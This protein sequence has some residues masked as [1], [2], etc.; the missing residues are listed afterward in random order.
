ME[1]MNISYLSIMKF[2]DEEEKY[3][4][5]KMVR[6]GRAT[7]HTDNKKKLNKSPMPNSSELFESLEENSGHS[8]MRQCYQ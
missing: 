4:S 8:T 6:Q 3:Q 2:G 7:I 1:V 5:P